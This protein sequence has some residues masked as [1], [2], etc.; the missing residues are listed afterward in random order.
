MNTLQDA[1]S[2]YETTRDLLRLMQRLGKGYWPDLP[3]HLGLEKDDRFRHLGGRRGREAR[4][5]EHF[6]P[7]R[8]GHR[9]PFLGL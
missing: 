9:R 8:P 7:G 5:P 1:W 4:R 3:W 6:L 2:W